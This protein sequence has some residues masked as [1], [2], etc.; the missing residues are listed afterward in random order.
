MIINLRGTSGSGKS[1][2]V[3]RVMGRCGYRTPHYVD[4]RKQPLGYLCG[5]MSSS[6]DDPYPDMYVIGH[7]ETPCGGADTISVPGAMD[8]VYEMAREAH[9]DGRHCVFEGLLSSCDTRRG[10]QLVKDGIPFLV[11]ALDTTIEVCLASVQERRTAKGNME[12]LNP[13]N[14]VSKEKNIRTAMRNLQAAGVDARWCTR[15][16]AYHL[17]MK[18]LG[19][20]L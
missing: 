6:L 19:L 5:P 10:I 11:I 18:E 9:A 8:A 4:G 2:V 16:E 1:S 20:G 12:P 7:Y 14:T 15:E 13:K 17:V 3:R